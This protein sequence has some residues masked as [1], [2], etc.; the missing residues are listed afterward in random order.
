MD[1]CMDDKYHNSR[2]LSSAFLRSSAATVAVLEVACATRLPEPWP[3]VGVTGA[4]GSSGSS[5]G[6]AAR[7]EVPS[8]LG[9]GGGRSVASSGSFA[10]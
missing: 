3:D 5:I 10:V 2:R 6:A 9:P 1:E 7:P 8:T 4:S